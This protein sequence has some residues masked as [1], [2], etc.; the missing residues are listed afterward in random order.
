MADQRILATEEM[1]GASHPTKNDTLNRLVLVEHD[2]DGAHK[3]TARATL[4]LAETDG[5]TFDHLHLTSGQ[6]S[7]PATAVP[8]ADPNT[9]DD[10]EKGTVTITA[11]C[12]TSG[13]ISFYSNWNSF[14][15]IKIGDQITVAGG[16]YVET[17]SSPVGTLTLNGLPFTIPN[18]NANNVPISI[19]GKGLSSSAITMLQG[20]GIVNS[21]T[22]R[23]TRF[24]AGDEVDDLASYIQSSVYFFISIIYF[25]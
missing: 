6:I 20:Y 23:I 3:T 13:S 14:N 5:P 8:S 1:V 19:R 18:A 12:G 16:L 7:F 4:G 10:Y 22:M 11:T 9:L 2:T 25:V 24:N 15:Y 21:T 17:V